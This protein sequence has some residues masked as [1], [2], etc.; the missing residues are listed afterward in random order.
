MS[1]DKAP[2]GHLITTTDIIGIL[3]RA[4]AVC[5]GATPIFK[6]KPFAM[7]GG[8][9]DSTMKE[10]NFWLSMDLK[11]ILLGDL[12]VKNLVS[13]E[14]AN[15]DVAGLF[16]AMWHEPATKFLDAQS[17]HNSDG[18]VLT[19]P[20]TTLTSV[21][22]ARRFMA[23]LEDEHYPKEIGSQ[24]CKSVCSKEPKTIPTKRSAVSSV[25]E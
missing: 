15:L 18:Y 12:K 19:R 6:T 16:F 11:F 3:G 13:G 24:E 7:I 17:E 4:C 1:N 25:E 21:Q 14:T 10:A 5:D 22:D 23:A 9:G 2:G 20:G 8:G